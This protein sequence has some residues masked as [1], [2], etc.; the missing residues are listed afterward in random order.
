MRYD[1]PN[2]K[3]RTPAQQASY[4]LGVCTGAYVMNVG[5]LIEYWHS[6]TIIKT[7]PAWV[8]III[9]LAIEQLIELVYIKNDR[10]ELLVTRHRNSPGSNMS[11]KSGKAIS[12]I[13][14]I[15]PFLGITLTALLINNVI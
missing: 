5:I 7:I 8:Y 1:S 10:Y 11:D 4:V 6:H 15:V 12:L 2:V 14:C 3:I 9:A 13:Y